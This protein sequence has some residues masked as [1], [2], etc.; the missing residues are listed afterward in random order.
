MG[1]RRNGALVQFV[2]QFVHQK[3]LLDKLSIKKVCWTNCPWTDKLSLEQ[4]C[5]KNKVLERAIVHVHGMC[6]PLCMA[7]FSYRPVQRPAHDEEERE[8]RRS[9]YEEL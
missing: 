5:C 1:S 9:A 2:G 6:I 7:G 3:C 4:P 8:S